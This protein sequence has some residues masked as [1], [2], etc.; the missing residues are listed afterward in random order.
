MTG[1]GGAVCGVVVVLE[2]LT[3]RRAL[4]ARLRAAERLAAMGTLAAGIAHEVNSPLSC[5]VA[6]LSFLEAEHDRLGPAFAGADL[7]EARAALEEARTAALRVRRIM[8]S[9]QTFGRPAMPL[10]REVDLGRAIRGAAQLAEPDLR[11]RASLALE[12][13]DGVAVRASESALSELFLG[14]LTHAVQPLEAGAANPDA[15]RVV[16]KSREGEALVAVTVSGAGDAADGAGRAGAE[17]PDLGLAV[18]HG[19]ASALGGALI[20]D[21]GP[22]RGMAALVRLPLA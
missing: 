17:R 1:R 2:D 9:L 10:L 6:G 7:V 19:I 8:R 22:G 15:L 14:L 13:E 4:D 16:M 5:V 12:L 18:C 21:G 3:K 11:G 20:V